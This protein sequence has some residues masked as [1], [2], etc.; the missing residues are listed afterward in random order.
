MNKYH[1]FI[2]N[3][4]LLL[5]DHL[6]IRIYTDFPIKKTAPKRKQF[7]LT[8]VYGQLKFTKISFKINSSSVINQSVKTRN[9]L[10]S[11]KITI[12]Q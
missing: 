8:N 2:L 11:Y 4:K 3:T 10:K 7:K 12:H 6:T 9:F 1:I 5:K